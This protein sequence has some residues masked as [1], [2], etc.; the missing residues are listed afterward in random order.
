MH[1]PDHCF[2]ALKADHVFSRP[3]SS[4]S[5]AGR[6]DWSVSVVS[7]APER[8]FYQVERTFRLFAAFASAGYNSKA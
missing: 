7:H 6:T 5:S 3:C 1:L 4:L 2:P 8:Q